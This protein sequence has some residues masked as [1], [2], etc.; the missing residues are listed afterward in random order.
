MSVYGLMAVFKSNVE[1]IVCM[2]L[3]MEIG[4]ILIVSHLY[5]HWSKLKV[6]TRSLY[7]LV[8]TVLVLL[9]S[10]EVMGFLAQSHATGT[11]NLRST[12]TA[13][14][15]LNKEEETLREQISIID[16][17]LAGLP[18]S[19]VSRRINERK[20]S[21]YNEK[22]ARLLQIAKQQSQLESILLRDQ[23]YAGPIFAVARIMQIDEVQAITIFILLL[24]IVLEP[25]SIGLTVATTAAWLTWQS[26]P[27]VNAKRSTSTEELN[28]IQRKYKLTVDQL[29]GITGRKKTR[30]CEEWLSGKTPVPAKAL[31]SVKA[32]ASRQRI[33]ATAEDIGS[34]RTEKMQIV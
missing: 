29:T 14:K 21:G 23:E 12:E 4:K 24:V 26:E 34:A 8:V 2:G 33:S 15:A 10:I 9:T 27:A 20:A 32:W 31:R 7:I 25:L 28:A 19:Y 16:A 17:T 6:L 11:L 1:I 13:L 22:Q 18:D 3:G 30:T 5:R